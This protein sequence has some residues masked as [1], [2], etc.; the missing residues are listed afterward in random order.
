[1][2]A[3]CLLLTLQTAGRGKHP[4]SM[5]D[6]FKSAIRAIHS[7]VFV[8]LTARIDTVTAQRQFKTQS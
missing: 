5:N 8:N 6:D 2:P 1:M 3:K 4:K 7:Y